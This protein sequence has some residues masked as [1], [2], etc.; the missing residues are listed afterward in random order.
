ML[1]C[2]DSL[3]F[4]TDAVISFLGCCF[5]K[6]VDTFRKLFLFVRNLEMSVL[7]LD[8]CNSKPGNAEN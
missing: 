1:R 2:C 7:S 8:I 5:P 3:F 6:G 4:R